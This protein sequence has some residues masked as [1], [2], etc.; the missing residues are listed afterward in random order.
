MTTAAIDEFA[1]KYR[2]SSE[3]REDILSAYK[4][5]G[6]ILRKVVD[7]VML[8]DTPEHEL[9]VAKIIVAAA[10]ADEVPAPSKAFLA[11]VRRLEKKLSTS[12][13]AASASAGEYSDLRRTSKR[14][15]SGAG[16]QV[17]KKARKQ[18]KAKGTSEGD[19]LEL[20]RQIQLNRE[21]RGKK[22]DALADALA[23]KY[24][25]EGKSNRKGKGKKTKGKVVHKEPTEE[26]FKAARARLRK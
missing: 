10:D 9:R 13:S 1:E 20:A 8:V 11:K 25:G 14:K 2:G 22:M 3:E 17:T 24:A 12:T 18:R 26:E 6:G 23:A 7:R 19:M 15:A 21:A 16:A 5:T 4:S